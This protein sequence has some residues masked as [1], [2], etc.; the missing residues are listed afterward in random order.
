M[1]EMKDSGIEWIGWTCQMVFVSVQVITEI[2]I[3]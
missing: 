2:L 1:R 3:A